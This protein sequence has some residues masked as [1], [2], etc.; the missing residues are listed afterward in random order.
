M[1]IMKAKYKASRTNYFQ[2]K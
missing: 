1:M 2:G